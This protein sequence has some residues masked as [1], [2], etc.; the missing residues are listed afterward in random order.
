VPRGQVVLNGQPLAVG[1][2][3]AVRAEKSLEILGQD[4]AKVMLFELT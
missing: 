3:A 2:E 1:D 4:D